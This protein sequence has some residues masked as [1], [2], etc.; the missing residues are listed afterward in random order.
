MEK[1]IVIS[2]LNN[3]AAILHDNYLYEFIINDSTYQVGN[4]YIGTA[5]KGLFI[6][7]GD[8]WTEYKASNSGLPHDKITALA[9]DGQEGLW[10]GTS[11]GKLA[12]FYNGTWTNYN[13]SNS[14]L[15]SHM[16]S[17]IE[18]SPNGTGNI[19][20]GTYGGGLYGRLSTGSWVISGST[21]KSNTS[22]RCALAI[23]CSSLHLLC[24][25]SLRSSSHLLEV[26][27]QENCNTSTIKSCQ[28]LIARTS[29]IFITELVA[30]NATTYKM[31]VRNRK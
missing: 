10:V 26:L 1:N 6:K 22:K 14:P 27:Q 23:S 17:D 18:T 9:L 5:S 28:E 3:L 2:S 20:I 4:I 12:Y 31:Y 13:S 16:I 15:Q 11:N 8:N 25:D 24:C 19:W 29:L 21:N 7:D 30:Q